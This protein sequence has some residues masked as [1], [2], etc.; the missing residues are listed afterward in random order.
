MDIY[1]DIYMDIYPKKTTP[2]IAQCALNKG[3]VMKFY[4]D[5]YMDIYMDIPYSL[6][7]QNFKI[8]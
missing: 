5:T 8:N 3:K 6:I 1:I 7:I 4:M 2:F